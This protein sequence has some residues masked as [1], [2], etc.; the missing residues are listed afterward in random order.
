MTLS[1]LWELRG[2]LIENSFYEKRSCCN[3]GKFEI[4]FATAFFLYFDGLQ[5]SIPD[6][7]IKVLVPCTADCNKYQ[8]E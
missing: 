3:I 7:G 2:N 8:A 6:L 1:D 5:G 4:P